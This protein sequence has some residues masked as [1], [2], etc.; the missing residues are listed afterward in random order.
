MQFRLA[1]NSR[2]L[3]LSLLNDG[4]YKCANTAG[5][6]RLWASLFLPCKCDFGEEQVLCLSS[7]QGALG[8][9]S[10]LGL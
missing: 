6:P 10:P 2:S 8:E 3:C 1:L 9:T 7:P 4:G 5:T